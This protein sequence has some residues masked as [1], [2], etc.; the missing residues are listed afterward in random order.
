MDEIFRPRQ[1]HLAGLLHR[2]RDVADTVGD[3]SVAALIGAQ[4]ERVARYNFKVLVM[5]QF[6]AGKTT[7]INSLLGTRVLPSYLGETTAIP[8]EIK[9]ASGEPFAVLYPTDGSPSFTVSTDALDDYLVVP[10]RA[11]N[12]YR[13]AEIYWPLDICRDGVEI[14][15]SP[16]LDAAVHRDEILI[17]YLNH[18]DAVVIVSRE[19]GAM[20]LGQMSFLKRH[21]FAQV[22]AISTFFVINWTAPD[23]SDQG[24]VT[25]SV[26]Q[27]LT[28][29][30]D[31]GQ[32]PRE[33]RLFIVNAKR[34]L[35][36][37]LAGNDPEDLERSG[38]PEFK[39]ALESFLI[40]E[41]G[42]AKLLS[43]AHVMGDCIGKLRE[44]I[45]VQSR[46]YERKL[47]S[48]IDS[49][50]AEKPRL[51]ELEGLRGKIIADLGRRI[52][53]TVSRAAKCTEGFLWDIAGEFPRW[54][55]DSQPGVRFDQR[56]S[57]E[58]N[59]EFAQEIT[60]YLLHQYSEEE[61]KWEK[62]SYRP[63]LAEQLVELEKGIRSDVE[64]FMSGIQEVQ[65]TIGGSDTPALDMEAA[66]SRVLADI[67]KLRASTILDSPDFSAEAVRGGLL[68]GLLRNLPYA[69]IFIH[70]I[71]SALAILP[72]KA[73]AGFIERLGSEE[74]AKSRVGEM[75]RQSFTES[76]PDRV[77]EFTSQLSSALHELLGDLD[78]RLSS[79]TTAVTAQ[80]E[81]VIR[82][83][84]AGGSEMSSKIAALNSSA[85][86]ITLVSE[87]YHELLEEIERMSPVRAADLGADS[88]LD[89]P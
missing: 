31:D 86:E 67:G 5:G 28:R 84:R 47:A 56:A 48:L 36:G 27:R 59:R 50:E 71:L 76:I 85:Q 68:P 55:I 40:R 62:L 14:A 52:D 87:S 16:G 49:Y 82:S 18:A 20:G 75:L 12:P 70:P 51:R 23:E 29:I 38:V 25:S 3:L 7:L 46:M 57:D 11:L 22:H 32:P 81:T 63:M 41:R 65:R 42:S 33:D 77:G 4:Q 8:C 39:R 89:S 1:R 64:R 60:D 21:V 73:A 34:A 83:M 44:D 74:K 15:D 37:Q 69:F 30:S 53:G 17:Q 45:A 66:V 61:L 13:L 24:R 88:A 72:A 26:R 79:E 9:Y 2:L 80:V 35:D 58:E 43:S 6:D 54:A 10:D 19:T 78:S